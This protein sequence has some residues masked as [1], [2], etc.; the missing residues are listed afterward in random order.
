MLSSQVERCN[1]ILKRLSLN[2]NEE[3]EFI[4]EDLSLREYIKEGVLAWNMAFLEAGFKDAIVVKIQPDDATFK[5]RF[6]RNHPKVG[7]V[8]R[9][10]C[11]MNHQRSHSPSV[12]PQG[13]A[14]RFR[15]KMFPA[16]GKCEAP[17]S[18]RPG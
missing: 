13:C 7:H 8:S 5:S 16:F 10:R 9:W 14:E 18:R 17:C 6:V 4:D 11:V 2:P 15:R 1:Q 12:G 3:D